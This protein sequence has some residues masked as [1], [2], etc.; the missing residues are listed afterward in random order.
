MFDVEFSRIGN[1]ELAIS[2]PYA[3]RVVR[4]SRFSNK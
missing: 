4:R 2:K 1:N 3:S